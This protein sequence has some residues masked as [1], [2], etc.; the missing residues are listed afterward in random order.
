MKKNQKLLVIRE[1]LNNIK[2]NY[3]YLLLYKKI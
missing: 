1:K 3:I 2:N